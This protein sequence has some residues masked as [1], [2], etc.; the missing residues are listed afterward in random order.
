MKTKEFQVELVSRQRTV[1][2]VRARDTESA[3]RVAMERWRREDPGDL[4]GFEWSEVEHARAIETA[5]LPHQSQDDELTLR[6]IRERE[7]LLIRLGNTFFSATM[8]DAISAQQV[9]AD[10]GWFTPGQGYDQ[11]AID[12][13]RGAAALERLCAMARLVC[14]ERTRNRDGERGGIRLYCT[15]EYLE[16][17]SESIPELTVNAVR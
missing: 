1:Y 8:N 11:P 6:F 14:F 4:G 10:L 15:P 13:L 12:V 5:R 17:L 3:R 7:G 9:A 2:T 16:S